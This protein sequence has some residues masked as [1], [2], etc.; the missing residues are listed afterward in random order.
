M[1]NALPVLMFKPKNAVLFVTPE[2]RKSADN[3]ENLFRSHSIG[4]VRIDDLNAYDYV[5]FKKSITDKLEN[6]DAD[7]VL[8][9]TGGTKLMALAAYEVFAEKQKTILYCNTE[10][11]EIIFLYPRIKTT[12][13][14]LTLTITDYLRAYGYE[15]L[16]TK[17]QNIKPEYIELFKQLSQN[18]LIKRFVSFLDNY[19]SKVSSDITVYTF[20]D[21]NEK[22]FTVQKT[23][24]AVIL[25]VG[26]KQYN[27]DDDKFLKGEWLEYFIQWSLNKQNIFPEVGVKIRSAGDVENEIDIVFIK[28]YQMHL[29]SCKSGRRNDPNKDIYE[30]ETL[31]NIAGGTF[32]KAYLVTSTPLTDRIKKRAE[33][34]KIKVFLL[35]DI[36]HT[37]FT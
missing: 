21:R 13:L 11:N 35:E 7:T 37:E 14:D 31:R 34:L 5:N 33:E 18:N 30:L 15:L 12:S 6:L 16:E 20:Q 29:I 22:F 19:R 27:F 17:T 26:T 1:A 4:V 24:S 2:E 32:G 9:V 10:N 23:T 3:L 36:T 28:N 8:N 25:F